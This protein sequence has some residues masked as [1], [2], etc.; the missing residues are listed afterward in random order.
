MMRTIVGVVIGVVVLIVLGLGMLSVTEKRPAYLGV[1]DGALASCPS[2]PNC[3]SSQADDE[4][5]RVDPLDG[6]DD[7]EARFA[8]LRAALIALPGTKIA[9][10]ERDYVHTETVTSLFRF[11]DDTELWLDRETGLIHVRAAA[12]TGYSDFGVNRKRMTRL[13]EQIGAALR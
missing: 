9:D 4:G 7:P 5:Q 6:G 2:S 1:R 8:A 10:E 13:G 12:R 3:V 11:T